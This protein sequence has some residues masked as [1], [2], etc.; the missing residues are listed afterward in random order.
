MLCS[1]LRDS[2]I[3]RV[4]MLLLPV[5]VMEPFLIFDRVTFEY[6]QGEGPAILALEDVSLQISQGEFVAVVGANGSGKSTF[7]R[8]TNGLLIPRSGAV[9]VANL[10]TRRIENRAKIPAAVGMVFQFP[11]DQ[12]ISTTVEEDTAFGPANLALQPEEIRSRVEQAL[13]DVGL[14]EMRRRPP[15]LLSAGQTQRLALA[16]VLAMRPSCIV[17]DEAS[18]MLDPSGRRS[19]MES[20]RRLHDEGTTVIFITHFMEEAAQADRMIVFDRGR[21]AV[22]GPPVDI[23]SDPDRLAGLKLGLPAAVRVADALRPYLGEIPHGLLTLPALFSALPPYRGGNTPAP[24]ERLQA[25]RL[26][27]LAG[28]NSLIAVNDL[29]HTYLRGTPLAQRALDGVSLQVPAGRAH[30]LLG[31]TGS[32]KSTL[33]QHLNGLLRPQEGQVRV[34]EFDLNDPQID[35]RN[36]VRR[37]GLVFQNPETQFFEHY[38][39]DE[40][41]FGPRQLGVENLAERVRWAMEQVGLDFAGYKDRTLFSLSGGERRKVALASTLAL[42]PSILLLDEPTAGLDPFSRWDL[43][44]KLL[45]MQAEGMTLVLSSHQMEDMAV[46]AQDLTVFNRGRNVTTGA[47]ADVF[48]QTGLLRENGLEPPAAVQAA[49]ELRQKGWPVSKDVLTVE[50]LEGQVKK[51]VQAGRTGER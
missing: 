23:F 15:H 19:L 36:V 27:A 22:D 16:G 35:R 25:E 48:S 37:A 43:L 47:A 42:Q 41:A 34:A 20:M 4:T 30:G 44:E 46:L 7:A 8:L 50:Q 28:S 13:K 12:I 26:P 29:G 3:N 1:M 10:D 11:E 18:T 49:A 6:E 21:V 31:M 14:W 24:E 51:A 33:L 38:A 45:Q 5:G 40:I 32:G 9:R 2:Q 39:G 17:F